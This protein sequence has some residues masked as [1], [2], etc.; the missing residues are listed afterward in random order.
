MA[1][2]RAGV[3]DQGQRTSQSPRLGE[4]PEEAIAA[5]VDLV[6]R[7]ANNAMVAGAEAWHALFRMNADL[8]DTARRGFGAFLIECH[9][10]FW[11]NH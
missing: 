5:Q 2:D 11:P 6:F 3:A 4:W 1:D 10:R 7:A 8:L 9:G